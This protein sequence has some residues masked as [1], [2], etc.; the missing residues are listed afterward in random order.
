MKIGLVGLGRMGSAMA[1]RLVEHGCAVTGWD[2]RAE[3]VNAAA[4]G[5]VATAAGP[6][7][8]AE[9]ADTVISIITEDHGVR[10]VFSGPDGFLRADVAGKLFIEMSTL[11]PMTGRALAPL[12]EAEGARLVEAPVLGTI[13]SVRAGKLLALAGGTPEDVERAGA[14]LR[15][16]TRRVAHLG[17]HGSGYAMKLCANLGLGAYIQALAESLALGLSQGLTLEQMLDVLKEGAIASPWLQGKIPLLLGGEAEVTLDIKTMRKDL[18]SAVATGAL[19]G[20]P[21]PLAA[22]ALASFSA[23]VAAGAGDLDL[24]EIA[25]VLRDRMLQNFA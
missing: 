23:A 24:A 13:P 2:R 10:Q 6:R 22:G 15:L 16:L 17:P 12:V 3:A 5:G 11:Q 8:V 9:A 18:M 25:R 7:A 1:Q 21:M 19:A 14:V 4:A 20:V